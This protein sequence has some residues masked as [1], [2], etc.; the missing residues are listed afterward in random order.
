MAAAAYASRSRMTDQRTG[1]IF[2]YRNVPGLLH[3][4]LV[5]W[6]STAE[7]L[8]NAAERSEVRSNARVARELRPALPA[9]LPH[10]EQI[11]LVHG[12]ACWLRE[13]FG[14]AVHYVIHAPR[15]HDEDRGKALWK[16]RKSETGEQDYFTALRDAKMTNLNFHAH[17]RFTTREVDPDTGVFGSKTHDIDRKESGAASVLLM[18][19]Q[20]ESRTNAALKR[21][22]SITRI[23]LRS[24][25][26]QAT[27]GDAP[28]GLQSQRHEGPKKAAINRKRR[29]AKAT[30][31]SEKNDRA[32]VRSEN[33]ALW[34]SW[35]LKRARQREENRS[36]GASQRIAAE[37]EA[38]RR[39]E[40]AAHSDRI[41]SAETDEARAAAVEQSHSVEN[42]GAGGAWAQAISDAMT[43]RGV[44]ADDLENDARIDPENYDLT[45]APEPD[46]IMRPVVVKRR[47][48]RQRTRG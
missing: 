21:N 23:D 6:K 43:G 2:N 9:E 24:Y 13:M 34:Q 29:R 48:P 11:R 4:G 26:D 40:A 7:D 25:A 39:Q 30:A 33:E 46:P 41:R 12:Y 47:S 38:E 35:D 31:G 22:G 16:K 1:R 15:F 36:S 17:I 45:Y 28:K 42:P 27:A 10:N 37:R 44:F 32:T 19:E 5:G 20:W 8:W 18:R 3:K 14:V